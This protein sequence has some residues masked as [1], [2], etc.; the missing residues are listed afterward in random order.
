MFNEINN[1]ILQV[2]L[3]IFPPSQDFRTEWER[4]YN[5]YDTPSPFSRLEWIETGIEVY[6]ADKSTIYPI[7]FIDGEG[8]TRAITLLRSVELRE[9]RLN[10]IFP[11]KVLR[12]I[13]F[14]SQRIT[15]IMAE[16]NDYKSLAL[17]S[18]MA[19]KKIHFDRIDL[20][21]VESSSKN[22]LEEFS[23]S[24]KS[25]GGQM[26]S[27]FDTQPR[28]IFSGDWNSYLMARTQGHRK[29]IRRYTRKLQE[30]YPDY[31]FSRIRTPEEF[32][33]YGIDRCLDE[34]ESLFM[35]SW[36]A[37]EL[38]KKGENLAQLYAKF[39]RKIF[40]KF[41]LLGMI[42]FASIYADG[43]LIAFDMSLNLQGHIY[44]VYG[45]YSLDYQER[46][47]GTA[48]LVEILK[49]GFEAHDIVLEFGGGFLQYK[50]IWANDEQNSYHIALASKT[51]RGRISGFIWKI[52]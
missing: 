25:C 49:S 4:L 11:V 18:L 35:E 21:K 39:Y 51:L 16:S 40:L 52:K 47:P 42:D 46:S 43:R 19:S 31:H 5:L 9:S 26:S 28:F 34:M 30:A 14:N 33:A 1:T 48:N 23:F 50:R 44:M 2:Q 12:T 6:I 15:P 24:W 22:P 38:Q 13:D 7:R 36:Q 8:I 3:E 45:A 17:Q 29:K 37:E 41:Y 27:V 10:H 32:S 20:F